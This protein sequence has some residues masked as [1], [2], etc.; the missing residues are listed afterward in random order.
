MKHHLTFILAGLMAILAAGC[1]SQKSKP[2]AQRGWI[3]G[4]YGLSQRRSFMTRF[5]NGPGLVGNLPKSLAETQRVAIKVMHLNTNAPAA[6]AGLCKDDFIVELNHEPVT[7]LGAFRR[8]IDQSEPGT[9]L[10]VKAWR[11]GKFVEYSIPVGRE[12]YRSG[13][14]FFLNFPTVVHRW[15]LWPNPGFSLICIGYEPDPG[16]R[17]DIADKPE[18]TQV[19]DQKWDA[20]LVFLELSKG[21]R[22][23]SQEPVAVAKGG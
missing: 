6:M 10:M 9:T 12:K 19:Y 22:V 21:E 15:D 8:T 2:L 16:L 17:Y 13:G 20:Y 14:I 5:D 1:A 3:G 18:G 7:S 11:D 4:E 23:T